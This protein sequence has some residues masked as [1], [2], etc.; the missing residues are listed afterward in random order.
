MSA[1]F[2]IATH[3]AARIV[4]H[5]RLRGLDVG[6]MLAESGLDEPTVRDVEGRIDVAGYVA[7]WNAAV[8]RSGD[9]AFAFQVASATS[10]ETHNLLRFVCKTSANVLEAMQRASRY[11]AVITNASRWPLE[12]RGADGAIIGVERAGVVHATHRVLDEFTVAEIVSLGR[13]FTG[14]VFSPSRVCFTHDEPTHA[15]SYR[16]FFRVP[17][18]FGHP[19]T[20]VHVDAAMLELP[21]RMADSAMSDFFTATIEALLE[22]TVATSTADEVRRLIAEGLR[23]EAP[24][25]E[26]IARELGTSARTLRRRLA[27]EGTT[28]HD[29]LDRT[30]FALAREHLTRGRLSLAEI[31]FFTGFSEAS[32]FHRAFRRWSGSTPQAFAR[33]ARTAL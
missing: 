6:A 33:A 29:L 3:I 17:V 13:T 1:R 4:D 15:Q 10:N 25:L 8:A 19:R 27:D 2:S 18:V 5:A 21:M 20:E 14:D 30:R 28:F 9:P 11:L 16:A 22:K 7:L 26:D 24:A 23:G 12:M 31:A 32:A